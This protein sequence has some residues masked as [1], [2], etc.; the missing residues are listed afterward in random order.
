M[1]LQALLDE[2]IDRAKDLLQQ[3]H[4]EADEKQQTQ[5]ATVLGIGAVKYADLSCQRH[6]Y[7][8]SFNRMLQFE[9]NTATFIL[10]SYVR[11]RGIQQVNQPI[12]QIDVS[13]LAFTPK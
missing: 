8:F 10:Y 3:R 1:R 11:V 12:D 13:N 5:E 9:G 2:A 4:P 7:K 6:D